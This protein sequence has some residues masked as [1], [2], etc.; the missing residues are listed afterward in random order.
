LLVDQTLPMGQ[1]LTGEFP[2]GIMGEDASGWRARVSIFEARP[3]T[4]AGGDV[5]QRIELQIFWTRNRRE[6]TF[7]LDGYRRHLVR[8]DEV[9]SLPQQ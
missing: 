4:G 3:R 9:G 7:D 6:Q 2:P 8:P 5:L 1:V